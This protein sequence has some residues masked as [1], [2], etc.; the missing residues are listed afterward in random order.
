[1]KIAT[2]CPSLHE[3]EQFLLGCLAYPQAEPLAEHLLSCARC[4]GLVETVKAED[5][6]VQA[7]RARAGPTVDPATQGEIFHL[8]ERLREQQAPAAEP[9]T[10]TIRQ[11]DVVTTTSSTAA[12]AALC[13]GITS[14]PY[15]FLAPPGGAGELGRLGPY[16]VFKVLGEGGMW[17][18]FEAEDLRLHRPAALKVMKPALAAAATTRQRFLREA[19]LAAAI[20]HDHV[21]AIYHADEDRGVPFLAMPLLRGETLEQRLQRESALPPAEVLRVGRQAAEGLAAAHDRGLVHRDIKPSNIWLESRDQGTRM[22]HG[23]PALADSSFLLPPSSFPKVKLLDFGLARS[24]EGDAISSPGAVVGTPQYM[25]P[26]QAAGST[27]DYRSDLFALGCVLYRMC[28]GQAPFRGTTVVQIVRALELDR[29]RPPHEVNPAVPAALSG[30]VMQLLAKAPAERPASASAVAQ[31]LSNIARQPVLPTRTSR[32]RPWLAVVVVL[33]ALLPLA[34]WFG[35]TVIR[36]TTNKGEL[37]IETDSPGVEVSVRHNG[38]TLVDRSR[39]RH[40]VLSAG[41]GEVDVYE[42]A[43]GLRLLTRK[44]TLRRGGSE[45]VS[46]QMKATRA[47]V[48]AGPGPAG[49]PP[50]RSPLDELDAAQIP[51]IERFAWQPRELVAVLGEHRQRHW[52]YVGAVACSPDGTLVASGGIDET[53]RLWDAG[54]MRQRVVLAGHGSVVEAV[55]FAPDGKTLATSGYQ[56]V[57]LWDLAPDGARQRHSFDVLGKG[58]EALAFSPDGRVLACGNDDGTL[59]LWDVSEPEPH[60]RHVLLGHKDKVRSVAFSPDGKALASGSDDKTVRLWAVDGQHV[61]ERGVLTAHT[62]MVTAV[63]F[64]PDGKTLV[65]GSHDGTVRLW[66]LAAPLP[67]VRDILRTEARWNTAMTFA[68]GMPVLA[69]ASGNMI[70]VWDLAPP[71]P[72]L[73]HELKG[74]QL[75]ITSV[76]L[77]PG[78][79]ALVCG[80]EDCTVRQWDLA[81]PFPCEKP[82]LQASGGPT[83]AVA[84]SPDGRELACGNYGDLDIRLWDLGGAAPRLRTVLRGHSN[85][86]YSLAFAPDGRRLAVACGNSLRVWSTAGKVLLSVDE[87]EVGLLGVAFSPDG[88]LLASGGHDGMLRLWD[89]ASGELRATLKANGTGQVAVAFSADGKRLASVG[90]DKGV[91]LWDVASG[92]KV[93]TLPSSQLAYSVCFSPDGK[94]LAAIDRDGT[95]VRLWNLQRLQPGLALAYARPQG[96][97]ALFGPGSDTLV[98]C[99]FKWV[100]RW[101]IDVPE[102]LDHWEMPGWVMGIALAPDGRHLATANSNGTVYILRLAPVTPRSD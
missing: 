51:T 17:I 38:A 28:T 16:R 61:R 55:A 15:D 4:I 83:K 102:P 73:I 64:A 7:L 66:D 37:V 65:S 49:R 87:P 42:P 30:L 2:P 85:S 46:A 81:G 84:F 101:Q 29:P 39:D 58:V 43:S 82:A 56:D 67:K 9:M 33:A 3:L 24:V 26:E 53:V 50:V 97:A 80:G 5:S 35:P 31:A 10:A 77:M 71:R 19:Q 100:S 40:F 48:P 78:G 79:K 8:I 12:A 88:R 93:V 21:V 54:T 75:P 41:D 70:R 99:G 90:P 44:F 68:P 14:K 69:V 18:V 11:S 6:L 52:G 34:Y 74:H 25:A 96:A 98:A 95:A 23:D 63:A 13:P 89:A 27:A 22:K 60:E 91:V 1:M 72:R 92:A 86:E 94:T 45:V 62:S 20:E 32:R 59:R 76:A 47:D 57:H 36:I